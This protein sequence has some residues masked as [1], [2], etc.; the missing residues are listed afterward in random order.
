M[1]CAV[2]DSQLTA[3]MQGLYQLSLNK[4]Y[5]DEL[6]SAFVVKPLLGMAEFCRII[7]LY[8]VD[9]LVDIVGYVPRLFGVLFR[10]IQNGLTQFY[11][12]A[13]ALG[14]AILLA[15]MLLAPYMH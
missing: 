14:L 4:F 11:A 13:M 3:R 10:P 6:Y 8:V 7:D 5:F 9:G 1:T 2:D 12:L 15:A